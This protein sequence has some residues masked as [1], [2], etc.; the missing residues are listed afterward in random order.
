LDEPIGQYTPPVQLPLG[1]LRPDALQNAPAVH[2]TGADEPA[3]Q[4][5]PAWHTPPPAALDDPC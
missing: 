1:A 5:E 2:G 4:N 3:G